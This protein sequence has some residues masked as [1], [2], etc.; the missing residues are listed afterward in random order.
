MVRRL[1]S[2]AAVVALVGALIAGAPS[3]ASANS[4]WQCRNIGNGEICFQTFRGDAAHII[5][6]DIRYRKWGGSCITIRFGHT[7][8]NGSGI[9][10]GTWFD[11]GAFQMCPNTTRSYYWS[12]PGIGAYVPPGGAVGGFIDALGQSRIYSRWINRANI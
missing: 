4:G 10:V 7:I 2:V 9:R 5:G 1:A 11:D 6:A 12:H 3:P 8:V